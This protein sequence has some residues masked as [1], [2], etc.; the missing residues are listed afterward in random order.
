MPSAPAL[1]QA[2]RQ[3]SIRL[4]SGGGRRVVTGPFSRWRLWLSERRLARR[5]ARIATEPNVTILDRFAAWSDRHADHPAFRHDDMVLTHA[6]LF[7]LSHRVTRWAAQ[8]GV[9][10]GVR[11]AILSRRA[12]AVIPLW[13][14][15][16]RA[17]GSVVVVDPDLTGADLA[18]ALGRAEAHLLIVS[19]DQ[20]DRFEAAVPHLERFCPVWLDGPSAGHYL[21]LDETLPAYS[22]RPLT[23]RDTPRLSIADEA[24]V[25]AT[26]DGASSIDHG[27]LLG[28]YETAAHQVRTGSV[29]ALHGTGD[30]RPDDL[31]RLLAS[32][33]EAAELP[34][35][36]PV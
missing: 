2:R 8:Q 35:S 22:D 30:L 4:R 11:V 14:G 12:E 13:L 3:R 5:L 16:A 10:K 9:R 24:L 36:T 21:R 31:P 25:V 6:A 27:R 34:D 17:G 19:G 29:S 15:I 33:A 26:P 32:L 20:Y 7:G 18:H 1:C 28:D 23:P